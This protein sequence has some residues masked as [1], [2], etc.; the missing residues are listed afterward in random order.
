MAAQQV[1][2]PVVLKVLSDEI[3][4]RSDKGLV[5]VAIGDPAALANAFAGMQQRLAGITLAAP[6]AYLL[7]PQ[8]NDAVE[9]FAG[10]LVDVE[11]GPCVLIGTGGVLV[12]LF[13]DISVRPLP[14]RE[15]DVEAMIDATRLGAL[16]AGFRGRPAADRAALTDCVYRLAEL[17]L[18]WGGQIREMDV[19]PILV[20][21]AGHGCVIVDA[22]IFP[23]AQAEAPRRI[24]GAS[25][26]EDKQ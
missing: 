17:G 14:L 21:P 6:P 3:P 8:I 13:N 12:E 9:V 26:S 4:H 24:A 22:V 20:L 5:Q 19:N 16:L 23:R 1:G 7:Q 25:P 18:H 2:F 10:I 15:G 11:L